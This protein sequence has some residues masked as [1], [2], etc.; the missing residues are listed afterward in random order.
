MPITTA[1]SRHI[2]DECDRRCMDASSQ[3]G[4]GLLSPR[5]SNLQGDLYLL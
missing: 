2:Q 4:G 3:Y 5:R 1:E